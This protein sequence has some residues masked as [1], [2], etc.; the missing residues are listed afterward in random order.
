MLKASRVL[1]AVLAAL[2]MSSA[3]AQTGPAVGGYNTTT[4]GNTTSHTYKADGA[5]DFARLTRGGYDPAT[6]QSGFQALLQKKGFTPKGSE[7][8][9]RV[10]KAVPKAAMA[11][12]IAKTLPVVGNLYAMAEL[13]EALYPNEAVSWD[14]TAQQWQ[15]DTTNQDWGWGNDLPWRHGYGTPN[16]GCQAFQSWWNGANS[17]HPSY[18]EHLGS[19]PDSEGRHT[20]RVNERRRATGEIHEGPRNFGFVN[21]YGN[22]PGPKENVTEQA[23]EDKLNATSP[24][25]IQADPLLQHIPQAAK[26]QIARDI[27]A[28]TANKPRAVPMS[29][30]GLEAPSGWEVPE[31]ITTRYT[32]DAQNRPQAITTTTK[33]VVRTLPSGQLQ[34]D[35]TTTTTTTTTTGTNPDGSPITETKT[36]TETTTTTPVPPPGTTTPNT[37]PQGED[38]ECGLPGTPPCKIDESGTPPPGDANFD[39]ATAE[40]EVF[41]SGLYEALQA[42]LDEIVHEWT[43]T[44]Q[45]PTGCASLQ[46]D[47]KVGPVVEIDMCQ[48]QPMIHDIMSMLWAA[49]GVWGALM[50]FL[51]ANG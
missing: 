17:E 33:T 36:D 40:I 2:G 22:V 44:F 34:H 29:P 50:I 20:C 45:L 42:K 32:N 31:S 18:M 37:P 7:Y 13:M 21:L 6:N 38:L 8:N 15:K 49:A 41:K 23:L 3:L 4:S 43:W 27:E 9:Y 30:A 24:L 16:L 26:E 12:A 25:P 11:K 39:A 1:L 5:S 14:N 46:F 48:W 47:T 35:T 10:T 19:V 51:R 28:D